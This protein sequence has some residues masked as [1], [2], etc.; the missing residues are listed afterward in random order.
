MVTELGPSDNALIWAPRSSDVA[1]G[2]PE[3][4]LLQYAL[5]ETPTTRATLKPGETLDGLIRRLFF[6]DSAA[7]PRAYSM[8][9]GELRRRNP[10]RQPDSRDLLVPAAPGYAASDTGSPLAS[11]EGFDA[12]L[13][14][15]LRDAT[16]LVR[17]TSARIMADAHHDDHVI[18]P[19]VPGVQPTQQVIP[20][21][22]GASAP[23][24]PIAKYVVRG[25]LP[26]IHNQT[27]DCERCRTCADV[28]GIDPSIGRI[29]GPLIVADTGVQ[30][31]LGVPESQVWRSDG[32]DRDLWPDDLANN[33]HGSFIYA[34][35][36][37][38]HAGV[39]PVDRV[40]AVRVAKRDHLGSLYYDV[41]MTASVLAKAEVHG[42]GNLS[43]A[44]HTVVVN[45]SASG[46]LA[47]GDTV[48]IVSK[49]RTL[50]VAAAGN[51][52]PANAYTA[53]EHNA[54]SAVNN[55]TLHL[56]VVGALDAQETP[57]R[58]APYSNHHESKVDILAQGS[59]VCGLDGV[60]LNGTSQAAP[61]AATAA[62]ILAGAYPTWSAID[63]K[64]RLMS[65]AEVTPLLE[66]RSTAG[67][68]NLRRALRHEVAHV[69]GFWADTKQAFAFEAHGLVWGS[70]AAKWFAALK[71]E[72]EARTLRLRR[73]SCDQEDETSICFER[74]VY[75]KGIM[76]P[77]TLP[78]SATLLVRMG[79]EAVR[80][81]ADEL[82]EIVLPL[83]NAASRE[84]V[85]L[86]SK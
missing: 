60:Q 12:A 43:K 10:D 1:P 45:Y 37:A 26:A 11:I 56:L 63:I 25:I 58:L 28:L 15:A 72:N 39:L 62:A 42:L 52:G 48:P 14:A 50:V 70:D 6:V 35:V 85:T 83:Y 34:Q 77:V 81:R 78:R 8:Y 3:Y 38:T 22:N 49:G 32:D 73:I 24:A 64:W 33:L 21:R 40:Y 74:M 41:P 30:R 13:T 66:A 5:R 51:E 20:L 55:P 57:P 71:A 80:I 44:A 17:S 69:T 61:M 9:L 23:P 59:C 19:A 76:G 68:L 54:F 47:V 31:S 84:G 2:S 67:K 29:A 18:V 53:A 82:A 86:S 7:H 36:A 79:T 4:L 75:A 16:A 65:S 46:P 27:A